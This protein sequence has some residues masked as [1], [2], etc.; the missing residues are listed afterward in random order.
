MLKSNSDG[1]RV[2]SIFTANTLLQWGYF[3]IATYLAAFL[4]QS[5]SLNIGQVA[6]FLSLIAVGYLIGSLA[7]GPLADKL[8][9]LKMCAAT[10]P[11]AGLTGLAL[12]LF[13]QNIWLSVFLGGLFMGTYG[14]GRAPF[15]S[16]LVSVPSNIRS[17]VM[18]TQAISN[19]LGRAL[20]ALVGGLVLALMGYNYLGVLCLVLTLFASAVFFYIYS[21]LRETS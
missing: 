5:Y 4:I 17:T 7:G 6:P 18:G 11:L 15:F 10:P 9:K 14:I 2:L 19:H 16:L 21:V 8:N 20:G 3:A 1:S 13:I 12:M